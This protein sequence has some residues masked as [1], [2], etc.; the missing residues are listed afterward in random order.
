MVLFI[1]KTNDDILKRIHIWGAVEQNKQWGG[2]SGDNTHDTK[3]IRMQDDFESNLK[4]ETQNSHEQ[5]KW[6]RKKTLFWC[7]QFY[8]V[9]KSEKMKN[10]KLT[11]QEGNRYDLITQFSMSITFKL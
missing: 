2:I 6:K 7:S 8:S 9:H 3:L 10:R 5:I 4:L 11:I 1:Y